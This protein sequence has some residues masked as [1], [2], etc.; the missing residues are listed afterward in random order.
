MIGTFTLTLKRV[1]R[2]GQGQGQPFRDVRTVVLVLFRTLVYC[3]LVYSH[4]FSKVH[5]LS[6]NSCEQ[7]VL[8]DPNLATLPAGALPLKDSLQLLFLAVGHAQTPAE[9]CAGSG[10]GEEGGSTKETLERQAHGQ[11]S[12]NELVGALVMDDVTG[13]W[14]RC[15]R[16]KGSWLEPRSAS[17][18]PAPL[19]PAPHRTASFRPHIVPP[20]SRTPPRSLTY[21][22]KWRPNKPRRVSPAS[23][24][25]LSLSRCAPLRPTATRCAPLRSA[26]PHC[27]PLRLAALLR[28]PWPAE[29]HPSAQSADRSG[30]INRVYVMVGE[31]RS[32]WQPR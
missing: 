17:R 6:H 22:A 8:C 19:R 14:V 25:S 31:Q 1:W 23:I 21:S 24:L 5:L 27:D 4:V 18:Q 9:S 16:S 13:R 3:V 11:A 2:L 10:C 26:A 30:K 7:C 20:P 29:P 15:G 32:P 28:F 12:R